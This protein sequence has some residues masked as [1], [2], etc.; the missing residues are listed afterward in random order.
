MHRLIIYLYIII[1]YSAI[2]KNIN[3]ANYFDL[4]FYSFGDEQCLELVHG[5]SVFDALRLIVDST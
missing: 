5:G 4:M 2:A 3:F 1:G